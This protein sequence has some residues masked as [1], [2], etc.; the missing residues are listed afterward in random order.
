M[1]GKL[2]HEPLLLL[3]L[4]LMLQHVLLKLL[5]SISWLGMTWVEERHL[6]SAWSCVGKRRM[7]LCVH[8]A[9]WMLLNH[10]LLLLLSNRT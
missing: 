3:L 7:G 9:S 5:G 6:R 10:H 4:I 2:F 1:S 8:E